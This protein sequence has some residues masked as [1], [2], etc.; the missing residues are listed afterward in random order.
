MYI[1]QQVYIKHCKS[2]YV[3]FSAD[4]AGA[5]STFEYVFNWSP[6][7]LAGSWFCSVIEVTKRLLERLWGR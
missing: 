3:L 7:G 1:F 5:G 4:G 6:K 2:A